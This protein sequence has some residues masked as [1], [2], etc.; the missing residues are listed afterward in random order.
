MYADP[1]YAVYLCCYVLRSDH[2]NLYNKFM[3]SVR[4]GAMLQK[5]IKCELDSLG[6]TANNYLIVFHFY[7]VFRCLATV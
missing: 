2:S 1:N 6:Q 3:C 4:G 5:F 7:P